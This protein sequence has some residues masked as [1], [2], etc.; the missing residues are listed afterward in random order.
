MVQ[1]K[2]GDTAYR[3]NSRSS[4]CS[5]TDNYWKLGLYH[6]NNMTVKSLTDFLKMGGYY[7]RANISRSDAIEAIGRYQRGLMSYDGLSVAELRAFCK[8]RGLPGNGMTASRLART[9]QEA[10]DLVTFP[11]F[12]DLPPEIRNIIYE[13]FYRSLSNFYDKHVQPP[14]TMASRQIRAESLS[15][16]YECATFDMFAQ[17]VPS[18]PGRSTSVGMRS[19]TKSLMYMPAA[20]FDRI[21][22]FNLF[23][24]KHL[25][26]RRRGNGDKVVKI[27]IHMEHEDVTDDPYSCYLEPLGPKIEEH[28]YHR[29]SPFEEALEEQEKSAEGLEMHIEGCL[30]NDMEGEWKSWGDHTKPGALVLRTLAD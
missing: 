19:C 8:A 14:L 9:L 10:D 27:V 4:I 22:T 17:C 7:C 3:K 25:A 28:L 1:F 15:L 13:L 18:P 20:N 6:C 30:Y 26:K 2:P 29:F 12:F 23:W 21:K 24:T 11:K 16:F 5:K